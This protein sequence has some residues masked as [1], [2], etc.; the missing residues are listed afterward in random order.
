MN[1]S[2]YIDLKCKSSKMNSILWSAAYHLIF[3]CRETRITPVVRTLLAETDKSTWYTRD[4]NELILYFHCIMYNVHFFLSFEPHNTY[5]RLQRNNLEYGV[6][7][8]NKNVEPFMPRN[9]AIL[10]ECLLSGIFEINDFS[11]TIQKFYH[12][13]ILPWSR[14]AWTASICLYVKTA[15]YRF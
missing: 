1:R 2:K 7:R 3:R 13:M 5:L 11:P 8:M 9:V 10:H 6:L 15:N 4:H 14:A 12:T